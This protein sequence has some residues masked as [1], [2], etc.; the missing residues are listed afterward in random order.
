MVFQE[1]ALDFNR[2]AIS[3]NQFSKKEE[4]CKVSEKRLSTTLKRRYDLRT[5]R[6]KIII[7]TH[8]TVVEILKVGM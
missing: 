1:L 3:T 8:L 6:I 4:K 2:G 7:V 5:Q